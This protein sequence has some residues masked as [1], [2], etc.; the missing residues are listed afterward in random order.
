MQIVLFVAYMLLGLFQ[1]AATM[2][3][4]EVWLGVHVVFA[5]IIALFISYIPLIGT[6]AGV[7]GAVYGWGWSWTAA[8]L[9]FF[10]PMVALIV[11]AMIGGAIGSRRSA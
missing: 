11:V 6:V 4:L 3:G 9:L 8:L 7:C 1:L 10:G 2:E 5:F